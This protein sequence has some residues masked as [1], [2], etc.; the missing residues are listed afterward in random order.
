V[1]F[2]VILFF[3]GLFDLSLDGNQADAKIDRTRGNQPQTKERKTMSIMIQ[4]NATRDAYRYVGPH[5]PSNDAP[6]MD[7]A[8]KLARWVYGADLEIKTEIAAW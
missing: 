4:I 1:D 7:A 5:G 6:T 3:C 8:K 2:F